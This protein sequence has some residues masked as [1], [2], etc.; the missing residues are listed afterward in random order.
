MTDW[1]RS[2]FC[3]FGNCVEVKQMGEH[4]YVRDSKDPL[5]PALT[6]TREEWATFLAGAATGDFDP[7]PNEE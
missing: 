5:G 2:S 6:F 7:P 3:N 4:V 1:I